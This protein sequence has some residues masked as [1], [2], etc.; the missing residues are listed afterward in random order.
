MM[1]N[2]TAAD[3]SLNERRGEPFGQLSVMPKTMSR[4]S[5]DEAPPRGGNESV[6]G[7]L[8]AAVNVLGDVRCGRAGGA[9]RSLNARRGCDGRCPGTDPHDCALVG[10]ERAWY[11]GREKEVSHANHDHDHVRNAACLLLG[12]LDLR[13]RRLVVRRPLLEDEHRSVPKEAG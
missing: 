4:L 3:V 11:R 13:V 8:I 10:Q 5:E 1:V 9:H 6:D 12:I 7:L 2:E